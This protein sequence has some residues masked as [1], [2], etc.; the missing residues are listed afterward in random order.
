MNVM[1]G[2]GFVD[3]VRQLEAADFGMPRLP[4][5]SVTDQC[6]ISLQVSAAKSRPSSAPS[7]TRGFARRQQRWFS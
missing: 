2:D 3:E 5:P 7:T 6:S 1:W 4:L